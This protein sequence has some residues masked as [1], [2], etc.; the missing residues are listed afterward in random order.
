MT[1]ESP[2]DNERA[3]TKEEL[4]HRKLEAEIAKLHA[5]ARDVSS[6]SS[7]VLMVA[8]VIGAGILGVGGVVAAFTT[9]QVTEARTE[10][11]KRDRDAVKKELDQTQTDYKTALTKN[12]DLQ[13]EN[14]ELEQKNKDKKAELADAEAR[15]LEIQSQAKQSGAEDSERLKAPDLSPDERARLV[16]NVARTEALRVSA[17]QGAAQVGPASR[18][19]A[20]GVVPMVL[21]FATPGDT[22]K[23]DAQGAATTLEQHGFLLGRKRVFSGK[24]PSGV[25]E[26]RF[27]RNPDDR[28]EAT[29][30]LE[31]LKSTA[32]LSEGRVSFV[33]DPDIKRPRYFEV[34]LAKSAFIP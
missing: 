20:S 23:S 5:E 8:R 2:P 1:H 14:V 3:P 25:T 10:I 24:P 6:R 9:Y 26:V 32:H 18:V 11:A 7:M 33:I 19:N 22:E 29:Q 34:R 30:I 31:L 4:E 15:F 17:Q 16:Q 27:F 12:A 21:V 28:D 13:K